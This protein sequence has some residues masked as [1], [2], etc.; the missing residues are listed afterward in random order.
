VD[1]TVW[2]WAGIGFII[3]LLSSALLTP[4]CAKLAYWMGAVDRPEARKVHTKIMPRLG[5]LAIYGGLV[6]S[7][8]VLARFLPAE[9]LSAADVRLVR[10]LL[11]GGTAITLLGVIDDRYAL[12]AKVKLAG[13]IV[14]A[15][16]VVACG[17]QID[18]VH[19]PFTSA[20]YTPL[21]TGISYVVTILWIVGVTNAINLIDGLDGLAAGV[22]GIALGTMLIIAYVT[23]FMPVVLLC[24]L[25]LGAVFGFLV[26]NFYPAKI[27][28]GDTGSMLLGF[29]I[30]T[31]SIAGFKQATL[32]SFLTP[33]LIIGVPLSDTFYAIVRR[34][35]NHLPIFAPDKGHLHHRLQALGFSHR[36]TVLIIYSIAAFFGLLALFHSIIVRSAFANWGT[37]IIICLLL[38]SVEL[39][40]EVIGI[41][42]KQSRPLIHLL[43]R[44]FQRKSKGK[45]RG[46]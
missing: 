40:A 23:G 9:F 43:T 11:I 27:F 19:L 13:Q 42:G 7:F 35:T 8:G 5:G 31:L 28:M 2:I 34:R 6:L 18:V 12:A 36:S 14:V 33:L 46:Q 39:G 22:A 24:T 38:I 15:I 4:L 37:F 16:V 17:V 32:V 45:S 20:A 26:L 41:V 29:A 10:G 30:A 21:T 3:A 44:A 25:L 1:T